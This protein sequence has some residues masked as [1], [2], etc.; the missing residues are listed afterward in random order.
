MSMGIAPLWLTLLIG[1]IAAET[2]AAPTQAPSSATANSALARA[3]AAL[4]PGQSAEF[5]TP[6]LKTGGASR[7]SNGWEYQTRWF[8]DGH[9]HCGWLLVDPANEGVQEVWFY[10]EI[11]DIWSQHFKG[12]ASEE[13]TGSRLGH[14]WD[15]HML[16]PDGTLY[17]EAY[18]GRG[19]YH[20]M[21]FDRSARGPQGDGNWVRAFD[22][23]RG[24]P[25]R[26]ASRQHGRAW[27]PVLYGPGNAGIVVCQESK[28]LAAPV[29]EPATLAELAAR[30]DTGDNTTAVYVPGLNAVVCGGG[31]AVSGAAHALHLVSPRPE[32]PVATPLPPF[33][34]RDFHG[35]SPS[36]KLGSHNSAMPTVCSKLLLHPNGKTALIL[37]DSRSLSR[38]GFYWTLTERPAGTW[39]WV[40]SGT[41][42]FKH[43]ATWACPGTT[44]TLPQGYGCLIYAHGD[45]TVAAEKPHM[46]L[47]K[48]PD[49]TPVGPGTSGEGRNIWAEVAASGSRQGH[50]STN[51]LDATCLTLS[52]CHSFRNC[53]KCMAPRKIA[54]L[55]AVDS[56]SLVVGAPALTTRADR[57]SPAALTS[58]V[59]APKADVPVRYE[60]QEG[61]E[62]QECNGLMSPDC[63][64]S[65]EVVCH[66]SCVVDYRRIRRCSR[67]SRP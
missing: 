54:I 8:F 30:T 31:N 9:R 65:H 62:V 67:T 53:A 10:D 24:L 33:R 17:F 59:L 21:R 23:G 25:G 66:I 15:L 13:V 50:P 2:R 7:A 52:G 48:V 28:I 3:C 57:T 47:W 51:E 35:D 44:C 56:D 46:I 55:A 32:G 36:V 19:T 58:E 6:G 5:P 41:H 60:H 4:A 11:T 61:W 34:V 39:K 40:L 12:P 37:E 14:V 29:T 45:I 22:L 26:P 64:K 16:A 63:E 49:P 1:A 20:I 43:G 18:G 38:A 27:H 42:P